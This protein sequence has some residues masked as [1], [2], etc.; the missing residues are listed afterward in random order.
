MYEKREK[1]DLA[2]DERTHVESESGRRCAFCQLKH[3]RDGCA[4]ANEIRSCPRR[5]LRESD[6]ESIYIPRGCE[7]CRSRSR[8]P[9]KDPRN[10]SDFARVHD[11]TALR[12]YTNR[13]HRARV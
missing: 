2:A 5:N 3:V 6:R 12:N 9:T 7:R 11:I 1:H 4:R 13:A 8:P 10:I